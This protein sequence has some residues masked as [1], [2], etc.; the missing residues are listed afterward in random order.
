MVTLNVSFACRQ[1][2]QKGREGE[3]ERERERENEKNKYLHS[4][5]E[6]KRVTLAAFLLPAG[7]FKPI[8]SSFSRR[9]RPPFFDLALSKCKW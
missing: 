1:V 3:R 8:F 9:E 5:S 4:T 2:K 7:K 6:V